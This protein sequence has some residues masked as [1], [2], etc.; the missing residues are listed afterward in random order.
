MEL[1]SGNP[2]KAMYLESLAERG[3]TYTSRKEDRGSVEGARIG[4]KLLTRWKR[5]YIPELVSIAQIPYGFL[6]SRTTSHAFLD[7]S[8]APQPALLQRHLPPLN[9]RLKRTLSLEQNGVHV[10]FML[11]TGSMQDCGG[12][13]R[14]SCLAGKVIWNQ[15]QAPLFLDSMGASSGHVT[16]P[17][18]PKLKMGLSD[19]IESGTKSIATNVCRLPPYQTLPT[20]TYGIYD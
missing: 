17:Y 7:I 14:V 2:K 1:A 10:C 3:K 20:F 11:I 13:G 12:S 9:Q 8:C 6:K 16:I 5:I 15:Y 19:C 18:E 4:S